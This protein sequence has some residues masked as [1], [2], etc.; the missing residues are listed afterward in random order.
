MVFGP[1]RKGDVP[2][3][4][5]LVV[6]DPVAPRPT[7]G[8]DGALAPRLRVGDGG[9]GLAVTLSQRETWEGDVT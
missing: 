5:A 6:M 3:V 7:A 4:G 1:G 8:G 2:G 9:R